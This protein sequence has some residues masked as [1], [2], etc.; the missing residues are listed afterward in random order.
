M[1]GFGYIFTCLLI[2][3]LTCVFFFWWYWDFYL[4][5]FVFCFLLNYYGGS[6]EN[7]KLLEKIQNHLPCILTHWTR[8]IYSIWIYGKSVFTFKTHCSSGI[9]Q[10][11]E[12]QGLVALR[13]LL[14][15]FLLNVY[16]GG[17][18]ENSKL[19]EKI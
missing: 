10:R 17:S 18:S 3:A 13:L 6:S 2:L 14:R 5:C 15:F 11:I 12:Q 19:L 9:L 7:S 1:R 8:V 16:G 4:G